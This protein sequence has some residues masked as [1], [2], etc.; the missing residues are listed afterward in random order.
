M[1]GKTKILIDITA[2]YN[3]RRRSV[4]RWK[5]C[6]GTGIWFNKPHPAE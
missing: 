2:A 1:T 3:V 6:D 4:G 5:H